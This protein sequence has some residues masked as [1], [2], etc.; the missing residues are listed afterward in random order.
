MMMKTRSTSDELT[1]ADGVQLLH[2]GF[3]RFQLEIAE[4][5]LEARHH[6][7]GIW[8]ELQSQDERF[9]LHQAEYQRS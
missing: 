4:V 3:S 7:I 2:E 8:E 6:Q 5:Q 1:S 9:W